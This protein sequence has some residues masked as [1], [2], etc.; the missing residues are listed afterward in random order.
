MADASSHETLAP[1][2]AR[3]TT[4]CCKNCGAEFLAK[5]GQGN[6]KVHCSTKC[7]YDYWAKNPS[8]ISTPCER[9]GED[10]L[11]VAGQSGRL[12]RYCESCKPHVTAIAQRRVFEAQHGRVCPDCNERKPLTDDY[13]TKDKWR[14]DG[15]HA[16]CKI[17]KAKRKRNARLSETPE[18]RE[19]RLKK[20]RESPRSR[21]KL[22]PRCDAE[23]TWPLK[24]CTWCEKKFRRHRRSSASE[25]ALKYCSRECSFAAQT[26]RANAKRRTFVTLVMGCCDECGKRF[27]SKQ[28]RKYCS[29]ECSSRSG[30]ARP[31]QRKC[32]QCSATFSATGSKEYCSTR[33]RKAAYKATP[34]AKA[35]KAAHRRARKLRKRGVSVEA[36]NSIKVLQRDRWTCQLCGCK[37]PKKLRGTYEDNAPEV[38][39]IIPLA[40]G[41]EHSYRNTQCACRKCN[42]EKGAKP[43]GQL[44]LIA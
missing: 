22:T 12:T 9:C 7:R 1:D 34:R 8:K 16:Y 18:Q 42:A 19:A 29:Q 28:R 33:C 44:R 41:G 38:D 26:A 15:R 40:A 23:K 32:P 4:K 27:S 25:D 39:H 3:V 10:F 37:T 17:C 36:V 11:R 35:I 31:T 24:T 2:N 14:P 43:Q 20:M 6:H 30:K 21:R 13:W 5:T